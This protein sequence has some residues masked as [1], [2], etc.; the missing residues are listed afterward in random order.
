MT[1]LTSL[2][3]NNVVWDNHACMPLRA[4]DIEFLDRL[5]MYEGAYGNVVVLNIG[6]DLTAEDP[7]EAFLVLSNFRA[8]IKE[9]SDKYLLIETVT[10]IEVARESG[11]LGVCFNIEGGGVLQGQTGLVSLFYDLG[12]RW[13]LIAYNRQNALGGGCAEADTGLTEFGR[14]VIDEMERVG[15]IL[16]C[17]HTGYRTAAEAI[18]Y[19]RKPV[20]F[21]HSN[22]R[23][24]HDH[25]RNIPDYLIRACAETGGVVNLNGVGIFLGE[26]D[27]S[28]ETFVRHVQYVADLV[29]H[30]HVGMG[31]DYVFDQSELKAFVEGNPDLYPPEKGYSD[32]M[33][34]I[35]PSRIPEIADHL[36]R[37]GWDDDQLIGF[38]GAN[39]LR[40]ARQV[41]R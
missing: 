21:S 31:L 1:S 16:C 40:V 12:V 9:R 38:L 20:I 23:A 29:G 6:F 26:N 41:W 10:D 22:P 19:S 3:A 17:S 14:R 34:M 25:E 33:R 36:L 32:G 35:A 15:M 24:L 2:M 30:E 4:E 7:L 5:D 13:M 8:W 27:D 28:T 39:N 11:R 18:E 37:V